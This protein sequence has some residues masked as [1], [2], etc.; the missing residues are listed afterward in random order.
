MRPYYC[1]LRDDQWKLLESI[2]TA[3]NSPRIQGK[4]DRLFIEAVIWIAST[5]YSWRVLPAELGDWRATY[6]RFVRWV[7][8]GTWH[9][10]AEGAASA[11]AL[12]QILKDV[13]YFGEEYLQRQKKRTERVLRSA[14]KLMSRSLYKNS[15][16]IKN[17]CQKY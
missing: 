5:R 14:Q 10:L 2:I 15:F 4:N 3:R 13:A 8:S 16:S 6:K 1:R 12:H 17:R 11:H 7:Q 9:R